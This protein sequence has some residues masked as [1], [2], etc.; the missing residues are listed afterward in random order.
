[1]ATA[2]KGAHVVDRPGVH[3]F[4]FDHLHVPFGE[5][6]CSHVLFTRAR[7]NNYKPVHYNLNVEQIDQ[8]GAMC[9][10]WH[11][12]ST[13]GGLFFSSRIRSPFLNSGRARVDLRNTV[14]RTEAHNQTTVNKL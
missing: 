13:C 2:G 4:A 5:A 11:P 10:A 1:M 9:R 8:H 7:N 3:W 14:P 6:T 12:A